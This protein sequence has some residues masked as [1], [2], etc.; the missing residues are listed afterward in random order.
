MT[1][2]EWVVFAA[3]GVGLTAASLPAAAHHSWAALTD[4]N[5]PVQIK[6]MLSKIDWINPHTW[7]HFNLTKADGTVVQVSLENEGIAGLRRAGFNGAADFPVGDLYDVTYY[8]NRDGSAGG[9]IAKII[10][11][12]Y[13]RFYE[14]QAP[15]QPAGGRGG[16]IR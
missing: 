11:V 2:T 5:R 4:T 1:S 9:F 16:V 13:G 15:G 10:N 3:A 14:E 8:P 6:M 12:A 7:L